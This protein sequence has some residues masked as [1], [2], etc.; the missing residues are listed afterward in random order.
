MDEPPNL[1]GLL[2]MPTAAE[3][4]EN[5]ETMKLLISKLEQFV[6]VLEKHLAENRRLRELVEEDRKI[7]FES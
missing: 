3:V 5:T 6:A 4:R 7:E 1:A 2:G